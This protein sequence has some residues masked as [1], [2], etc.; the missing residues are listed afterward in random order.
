MQR[1][2]LINPR[3]I[4]NKLVHNLLLLLLEKL[5]LLPLCL[6]VLFNFFIVCQPDLYVEAELLDSGADLSFFDDALDQ[7]FVVVGRV[8]SGEGFHEVVDL[9][10]LF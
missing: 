7:F 4:I 10:L 9:L 8:E 5:L 2:P 6:F 3:I 1:I